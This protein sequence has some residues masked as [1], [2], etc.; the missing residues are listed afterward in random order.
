MDRVSIFLRRVRVGNG[1]GRRRS[2]VVP[3]WLID[4]KER[5]MGLLDRIKEMIG[6]RK[7]QIKSGIDK[8][9]DMIEKRVSP[10]NAQKVED[11][12]EKAK[13]AVD[14]LPD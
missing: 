4:R 8:G 6:G 3:D 5:L 11:V 9:S 10:E 2:R 14:K 13:D 12:A 7:G 1:I